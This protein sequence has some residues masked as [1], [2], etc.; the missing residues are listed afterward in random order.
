M[1]LETTRGPAAAGSRAR[2]RRLA[3]APPP[4]KA[5]PA[6]AAATDPKALLKDARAALQAN[7]FNRAQDLAQKAEAANPTGKWGLFDDTP[8]ALRRDIAAARAK[9]DKAEVDRL[10]QQAKALF[11]QPWRTEAERASHVE[12]ALKLAR[13]ADFLHGP[14][15]SVW[16]FGDRP[17]KLVKELD[18]A[19]AQA[20]AAR[21][22]VPAPPANA[23]TLAPIA[24]K[25]KP[26]RLPAPP[27]TSTAAAKPDAAAA[28]ILPG[29][30][31]AKPGSI[32]K[33]LAAEKLMAEGRQLA[34]KGEFV[35]AK[36]KYDEADTLHAAFGPND[37]PGLRA[38]G[39]ERPRG[40]RQGPARR[41][42][43]RA[44]G[45]EGLR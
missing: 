40:G 3:A 4:P 38:P 35:A 28:P 19:Q 34:G 10:T 30:S 22:R 39:P 26:V 14:A 8:N 37:G 29:S 12:Q 41:G 16:E 44:D 32:A 24:P 42:R 11:L 13:R 2:R 9:T 33:Q 20:K 7:D 36:A 17:D 21:P 31:K 27:A 5:P 23:S 43:R 6:A 25:A 45:Q 15:Y 18:A 1:G